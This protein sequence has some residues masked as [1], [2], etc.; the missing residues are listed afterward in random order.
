MLRLCGKRQIRKDREEVDF[1]KPTKNH[2]SSPVHPTKIKLFLHP[3]GGKRGA[4]Q[5]FKVRIKRK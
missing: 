5:E 3:T 1:E 2:V 4:L